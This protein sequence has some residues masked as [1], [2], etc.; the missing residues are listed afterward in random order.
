MSAF[1]YRKPADLPRTIPLF[2]LAG[3]LLFPRSAL[4]LNVFEPRYLNMI[5]DALAGDRLIGVIQPAAGEENETIPKLSDVGA[6]GR[7]TSF[8][9]TE[10]G[11]Y[12]VTLTG[13]CRFALEHEIEAD[14]PYRQALVSYEEFADDFNQA[15]GRG[16]DR[17]QLMASLRAYAALQGFQVDWSA[18]DKAPIETVV[19]LAAQL[20]PFDP[21]A[22]QALLEAVSLEQRCRALIALLEW[23]SASGDSQRPLQ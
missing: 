2:P 6:V 1:G 17:E 8:T 19:N 9:E 21:A 11:R 16:I 13:V 18:V 20:C 23:D 10:D 22:K 4:S 12:L 5:D 15:N 7:I 14:A 3:A